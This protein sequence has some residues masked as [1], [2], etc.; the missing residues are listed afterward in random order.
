LVDRFVNETCNRVM[1]VFEIKLAASGSAR[2]N[3]RCNRYGHALDC[4][5]E[6]E[7]ALQ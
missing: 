2:N 1:T 3:G 7:T 6:I 5:F 4:E